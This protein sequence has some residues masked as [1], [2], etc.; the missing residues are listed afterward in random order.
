MKNRKPS[1]RPSPTKARGGRKASI[2]EQGF[3]ATWRAVAVGRPEPEREFHFA[4]EQG[5]M[6]RFDFAF[7]AVRL[8]IEIDGGIF[9]GGS[10]S[11]GVRFTSDCEKMNLAVELGWRVLRYT[12]LDLRQRP[13]QCVEQVLRLLGASNAGQKAI[14]FPEEEKPW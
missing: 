3:L 2:L 11:R 10:H 13:V 1:P 9:V 4:K 7:S 5:R 14:E 6:F 12:T 8:G